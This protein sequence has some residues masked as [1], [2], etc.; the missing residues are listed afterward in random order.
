MITPPRFMAHFFE[1]PSAL[2]QH[3]EYSHT[4]GVA[5]AVRGLI[6]LQALYRGHLVRTGRGYVVKKLRLP[7]R[8]GFGAAAASKA[9]AA[10]WDARHHDT[11]H[12]APSRSIGPPLAHRDPTPT[13][14]LTAV[15]LILSVCAVVGYAVRYR[16]VP[17]PRGACDAQAACGQNRA[18][19]AGPPARCHAAIVAIVGLRIRTSP[20]H[21][22]APAKAATGAC[23]GSSSVRRGHSYHELHL[24]YN[25]HL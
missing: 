9:Q 18:G 1:D 13:A 24:I 3:E 17:Q 19:D 2:A 16:A 10:R 12:W 4:A 11:Q 14:I 25:I 22:L 15:E 6:K 5:G 20:R 23:R 21:E 7:A 8:G